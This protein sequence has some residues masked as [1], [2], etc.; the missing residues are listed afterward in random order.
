MSGP[1]NA[2]WRL[3]RRWWWFVEMGTIAGRE[4]VEEKG[5]VM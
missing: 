2:R 5:D 3:E 1:A 4:E